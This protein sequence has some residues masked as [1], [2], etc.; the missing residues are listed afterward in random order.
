MSA[1]E[2]VDHDSIDQTIH[3]DDMV[4]ERFFQMFQIRVMELERFESFLEIF[5]IYPVMRD[6]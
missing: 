4:M 3:P 5:G 2:D 1:A 6:R